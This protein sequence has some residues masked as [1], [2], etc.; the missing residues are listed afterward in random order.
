MVILRRLIAGYVAVGLLAGCTVARIGEPY[1]AQ[2]EAGLNSYYK[3]TVEFV[4]QAQLDSANSKGRY[5][6]SESNTY[7]AA[8]AGML[9]DLKLRAEIVGG[10]R[11]C[12]TARI[13][14]AVES[15]VQQQLGEAASVIGDDAGAVEP[16]DTT[17]N[18][19]TL[20]IR[21]VLMAHADLEADHKELRVITPAVGTI[22]MLAIEAAVRVALQAV[23]SHK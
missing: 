4:K 6:S 18:C 9:A 20:V 10:P 13:I 11:Q 3:S 1:D 5:G 23:T 22:N 8:A 19:T 16:L 14:G 15:Q 17:G 12:P 7:Y 21:N 2:L